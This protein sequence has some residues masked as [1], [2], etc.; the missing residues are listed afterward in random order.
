MTKMPDPLQAVTHQNP[1][2]TYEQLAAQ[3]FHFS[4][5]LQGWLATAPK[6]IAAVLEDPRCRVR[7][8]HQP[9]P[10]LLTGSMA[11]EIFSL[12]ARMTDGELHHQVKE[13]LLWELDT[14]SEQEVKRQTEAAAHS[15][16][17]ETPL[18]FAYQMPVRS[19]ALL[20]G[21]PMTDMEQLTALMKKFA[22]CITPGGP[23]D[24]LQEGIRAAPALWQLMEKRLPSAFAPALAQKVGVAN[25][26]G[27]L[28]QS[29]DSTASLILHGL[30]AL[31][32]QPLPADWDGF[33]TELVRTTTPIQNTRRFMAENG[34]LLDQNVREGDTLLLILAVANLNTTGAGFSFGH[35]IHHCPGQRLSFLITK[36]ALTFW[37]HFR[38]TTKLMHSGFKSS[39]NAR[40]PLLE[41]VL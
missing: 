32:Q 28:W 1:T 14:L 17:S 8:L 6:D 29:Y 19:M 36:T 27:L 30:L 13:S 26:I 11:G 22:V 4:S 41:E 18:E 24:G 33:L 34:I 10:T 38:T 23:A 31:E 21:I 15:L 2:A 3:P 16:R 5:S 25:A 40:I 12:L 9:V 35:G 20:L 37:Q 39:I 7:P